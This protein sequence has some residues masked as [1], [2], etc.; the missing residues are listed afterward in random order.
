MIV[1]DFVVPKT[2]LNPLSCVPISYFLSFYR[3]G[4][5]PRPIVQFFR[6]RPP[7]ILF[8]VVPRLCPVISI[9]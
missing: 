1:Q 3:R 2:P 7:W 8:L 5:K 9:L 4:S 6:I